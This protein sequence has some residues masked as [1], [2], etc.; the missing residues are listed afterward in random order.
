MKNLHQALTN[1]TVK[2]TLIA[3]LHIE[4]TLNKPQSK[5]GAHIICVCSTSDEATGGGVPTSDLALARLIKC[6]SVD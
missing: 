6:R 1:V 5:V 2:L 3:M 4:I